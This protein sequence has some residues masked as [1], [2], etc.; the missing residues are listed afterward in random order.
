MDEIIRMYYPLEGGNVYKRIK[1]KS[2]YACQTRASMLGV[3]V[4]DWNDL[5]KKFIDNTV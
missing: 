1:G 2:K 4:T 3:K 5:K